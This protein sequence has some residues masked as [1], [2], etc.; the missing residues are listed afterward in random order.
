MDPALAYAP[1]SWQVL[2]ATCAKLLN[3]PDR[4]GAAGSQLVPEVAQSLPTISDDG[5]TYTFTIRKGFRFSPPSNAAVTAQTFKD[6]IERT[7]N[8]AMKNPVASEFDDI[9]GAR[10]YMA[11]RAPHISGVVASGNTL[12]IRLTAPA[13][14]LPSRI[15]Q[16]F[17][18]VVPS[19]TPISPGGERV[20]PSAGPYYVESYT[21]GQG[22]VLARNPNYHGNRP[23]RSARI[24][25]TVGIPPTRAIAQVENGTADYAVD[26]EIDAADAATLAA[27]YGPGSPAAKHGRQQYFI[28]VQDELDFFV[29]NTHRPLFANVRLRQAV[30]YAI[31]RTTLAR[32]GDDSSSLPERPTDSYIPPG[33]PGYSNVHVYPLTPDLAKARALARGYAGTTVVMFTCAGPVCAEQAQVVKTDLAAIG[34]GVEIKAFPPSVLYTKLGTPGESFDIAEAQWSA[35]YPDPDDFLNLPL[36]SGAVFPTLVDPTYRVRLAAAARLTG[37]ERY[38]TYA[39]LEADLARKAAPLVAYGNASTHELFS[40]RIGC[41]TSGVYGTD[42]AALCARQ[43]ASAE[44]ST[45]HAQSG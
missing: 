25:L 2:Y 10:S 20:I 32:L 31:D 24:E 37:T 34:L 16:P 28:N 1:L 39:G 26:G 18:C 11:G 12:T 8:P 19:D 36:E 43:P 5:R 15:A 6:T 4:G 45:T 41:Q 35:D 44:Q 30:N 22:V 38:L 23:H 3:Y 42:L 40:A 21:P 7:L 9:V 13:P 14:D 27:R 17:F 33:V 29:L